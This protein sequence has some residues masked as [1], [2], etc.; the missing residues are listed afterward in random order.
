MTPGRFDAVFLRGYDLPRGDVKMTETNS[1]ICPNC[2]G[3]LTTGKLKT[4]NQEAQIVIA[5]K[6]DGFL[7]VVPFTTAQISAQVCTGCGRIE[8]YARNANDL[9]SIGDPE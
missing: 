9:L 1:K 4:G 2:R 8:L 7:G 5:G 3:S 6:P